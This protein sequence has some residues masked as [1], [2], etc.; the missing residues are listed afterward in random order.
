M[1]YGQI[2]QYAPEQQWPLCIEQ[3]T[4][5]KTCQRND[6]QRA[7]VSVEG[8]AVE[9]GSIQGAVDMGDVDQQDE[10]DPPCFGDGIVVLEQGGTA[11]YESQAGK[12]RKED[13]KYLYSSFPDPGLLIGSG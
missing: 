5:G 10:D 2:G 9:I 3:Y 6:D 7:T 12:R 11:G 8:L 13:E 1:K 4:G